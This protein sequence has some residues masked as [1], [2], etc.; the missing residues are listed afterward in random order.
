MS[1]KVTVFFSLGPKRQI[2]VKTKKENKEKKRIEK[3]I[4]RKGKERF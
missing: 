1:F 3:E 2:A 4:E